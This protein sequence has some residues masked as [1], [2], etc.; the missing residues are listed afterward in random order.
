MKR[1][2][3]NGFLPE[4][5]SLKYIRQVGEALVEVHKEKIVHQDANPKNIMIQPDGNA[6]LIDFGIAKPIIPSTNTTDY[7]WTE[8]FAPYEQCCPKKG[9]KRQPTLDIYS[10]A[11]TFYYAVTD[12]FPTKSYERQG[13]V[14]KTKIDPLLSPPKNYF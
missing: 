8:H 7:G 12:E 9:D 1:V 14:A 11:A 6:V 13:E 10:L 3:D 4:E 2:Q 5:E